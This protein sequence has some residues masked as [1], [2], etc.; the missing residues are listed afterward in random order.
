MASADERVLFAVAYVR[1]SNARMDLGILRRTCLGVLLGESRMRRPFG[2]TR[3]AAHVTPPEGYFSP[4]PG[5]SRG[6]WDGR[7]RVECSLNGN[8][9]TW[10]VQHMANPNKRTHFATLCL[11]LGLMPP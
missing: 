9:V 3:Y 7:G 5:Q 6:A 4:P 2:T 10:N 8:G 11:R 1:R